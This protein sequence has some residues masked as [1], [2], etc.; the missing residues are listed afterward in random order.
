M[1]V[2]LVDD[3]LRPAQVQL[4]ALERSIDVSQL[5]AHL[6]NQQTV[7]LVC[8]VNARHALVANLE[9]NH[10]VVRAVLGRAKSSFRSRVFSFF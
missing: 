1:F 4:F 6:A 5:D 2:E 8:P 3:A 7:V 10:K 9:R